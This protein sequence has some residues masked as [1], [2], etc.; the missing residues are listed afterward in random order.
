MSEAS[1]SIDAALASDPELLLLDEPSAG[2]DVRETQALMEEVA[3]LRR[4]RPD[5]GVALIEHDM[6][7]VRGLADRVVALNYGRKIA[8][9]SFEEVARSPEVREAYLGA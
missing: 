4:R 7:V 1:S 6:T 3:A 8:E 2:M 5:L 9:G